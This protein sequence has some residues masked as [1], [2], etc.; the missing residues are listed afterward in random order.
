M[1]KVGPETDGVNESVAACS[2]MQRKEIQGIA[3]VYSCAHMRAIHVIKQQRGKAAG[4]QLR[5]HACLT[6]NKAAEGES[7]C[8]SSTAHRFS[9]TVRATCW[10]PAQS[11]CWCH[12][13]GWHTSNSHVSATN[14]SHGFKRV[15]T[16]PLRV[17]YVR[18]SHECANCCEVFAKPYLGWP[19]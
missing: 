14:W 9:Q 18:A 10:W 7:T 11:V 8:F 15:Y 3:W 2:T 16:K 4:C 1:P 5:S 17:A 19:E 12:A 6:C 13:Y